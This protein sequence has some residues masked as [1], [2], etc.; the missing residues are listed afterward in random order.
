[1]SNEVQTRRRP[2]SI[3]GASL[4]AVLIIL[5]LM[6]FA[7]LA[8]L[9]AQ[10]ERALSERAAASVEAY[11]AAEYRALQR[12]AGLEPPGTFTEEIDM[13]RELKVT[14]RIVDYR[15]VIDEWAVVTKGTGE[16]PQGPIFGPPPTF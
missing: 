5:C 12:I 8:R 14:F 3:G 9:S 16:E 4:F 6:V 11:Y 10:S 15:T 2:V 1:M 13:H 7:V